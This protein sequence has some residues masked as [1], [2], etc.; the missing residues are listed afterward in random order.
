MGR[1]WGTVSRDLVLESRIP[2][3]VIREL[4]LRGHPVKMAGGWEGS[5]GHAQAIRIDEATGSFEGGADPRG[6]G[7]AL[8]F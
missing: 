8:G 2:E 6:D 5:L 4:R 7:I 3:E 1:T